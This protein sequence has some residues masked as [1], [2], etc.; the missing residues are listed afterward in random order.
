MRRLTLFVLLAALVPG[1]AEAAGCTPES[2]ALDCAASAT[3]AI[4]PDGSLVLAWSAGGRVMA[5][6]ASY[7][8]APLSAPV[9]INQER[10]TIDD[11]GEARPVVAIDAKGRIAL[12]YALRKDKAFIGRLMVTHSTDGGRS[13]APPRPVASDP[14]SQRF[15]VMAAA[16]SG[17]IVL[18]WTDK[19]GQ[20]AAKRAG[21]TYA[22]SALFATWSEDGGASFAP[23]VEIAPHA[24]ECCRLGLDFEADSAP[25]L[26]W[27][28]IFPPGMRDHAVTRLGADGRPAEDIR[29]LSLDEWKIDACPHHGPA[30][31]VTGGGDRHAVWFTGGGRR[32][33]IYYARAG[34]DGVFGA[35]RPLGGADSLASHPF[36]LDAGEVVWVAW[37]EFD[38][39][40]TRIMVQRST[41]GGAGWSTPASV[42]ETA[43]ASDHPLLVEDRGVAY[44]SW[45]SKAEGWRLIRLEGAGR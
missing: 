39:L 30:L 25:V 27:R 7:A 28:H 38:G 43:D 13:F 6:V 3:P 21:E 4:G 35:A 16:P 26:V 44:L 24:C 32:K 37:K 2:T 8:G 11:H 36:V 41:D 34:R 31:A 10:Q 9:V 17:R 42:A 22:G 1:A 23:E 33:G 18:G 12:A 5:A 20:A 15:P 14:T 29:R 40:R 45:L 19:R